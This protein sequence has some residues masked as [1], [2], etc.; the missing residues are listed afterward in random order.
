MIYFHLEDRFSNLA[1]GTENYTRIKGV[2]KS[3]F[4]C[5]YL[6][7]FYVVERIRRFDLTRFLR[8]RTA[9]EWNYQC[10][11]LHL[12]TTRPKQ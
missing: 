7:L 12:F 10:Q 4:T 5:F 8:L 1:L 6:H 3:G 11:N 9:V 2:D